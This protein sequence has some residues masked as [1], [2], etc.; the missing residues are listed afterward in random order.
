MADSFKPRTLLGLVSLGRSKLL[1]A[2]LIALVLLGA[3]FVVGDPRLWALVFILAG[4]AGW[5]ALQCVIEL[6]RV[7]LEM[8]LPQ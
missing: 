8:L 3:A 7:V 1:V 6:V 2:Y 5:F 4:V